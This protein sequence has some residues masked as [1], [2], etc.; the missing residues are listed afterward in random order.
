MVY[1]EKV[2]HRSIEILGS[3]SD[4]NLISVIKR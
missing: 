4:Y 2:V 1:E 3:N